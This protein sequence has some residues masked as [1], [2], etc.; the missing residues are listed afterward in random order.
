MI[1]P[2]LPKPDRSSRRKMSPNTL[3]SNMNHMIQ[4]KKMTIDHN[5]SRNG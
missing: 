3:N 4:M 1:Q 5:T 2:V